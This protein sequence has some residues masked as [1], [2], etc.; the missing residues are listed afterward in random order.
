MGD[1]RNRKYCRGSGE[2]ANFNSK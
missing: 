2:K 1:M